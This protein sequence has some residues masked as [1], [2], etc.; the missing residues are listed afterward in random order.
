MPVFKN[1]NGFYG[2][3]GVISTMTPVEN[4]ER[5]YPIFEETNFAITGV[6]RDSNGSLLGNCNVY[7]FRSDMKQDLQVP[8]G[9][10][11]TYEMATVSDG[12]GN[13]SFNPL[14]RM[15]GNFFVLAWSADG[16]TAGVTLTNLVPT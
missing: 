9:A 16:L 15:A 6:T 14:S 11:T 13:F 2:I 5:N 10:N 12:S 7:L 8:G 1:H 4:F 3:P